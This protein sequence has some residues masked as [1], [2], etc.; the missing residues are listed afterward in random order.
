MHRHSRSFYFK[1]SVLVQLLLLIVGYIVWPSTVLASDYSQRLASVAS[2]SKLTEQDK[3]YQL[4]DLIWQQSLADYPELGTY[5][6]YPAAHNRWTDLTPTAMAERT[7]QTPQ[8]LSALA[9]IDTSQLDPKASLEYQLVVKSLQDTQQQ[10][11]FYGPLAAGWLSPAPWPLSQM[12][13]AHIEVPDVI[14]S[15]PTS[16]LKDYENI[17]ARLEGLP[18]LME[19]VLGL[20][21]ESK[22]AELMPPKIV[23]QR[24]IEQVTGV[25]DQGVDDSSFLTSFERFPDTIK[26]RQQKQLKNAAINAVKDGVLPAYQTL[27]D[28]LEQTYLPAARVAVG[29]SELPNGEAWYAY[30]A[31]SYTT[32]E[33]TPKEIHNIGLQEVK[34][35]RKAM[36]STMKSTGFEGSL[37]EFFTF[38]RTDPQFFFTEPEQLL[39][40]YRDIA[41]QADPQLVK[42]FGTLPR[43]PYGV[44][45][46]PSYAEKSAPTAYYMSGTLEQGRAGVFFANTYDL[47]SRPK[48]EMVA[49][50]LHEAVPGHHLQIALAQEQEAAHD[51]V[52]NLFYTAF[53]EGWGLYS[54]SLGEDMAMYDD[55][56]DKFGQLTY[57]MWR[58]VRLVVD[59]G[60]HALG[61]SRQQAIDYFIENAGKSEHDIT[62][63]VDRYI[64]MP[65]QALAYKIGEL[66]IKALR[67]QASEQL[68]EAFNLRDFHDAILEKGALPLDVLEQRTEQWIQHTKA[69]P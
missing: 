24:V 23:V 53:I 31:R 69:Q 33:L 62:V 45:P 15:M 2:N 9:N 4:F 58:A 21:A 28:Y 13:G 56:Y 8:E 25:L 38:L 20:L 60:M 47:K 44:S 7:Q 46:I 40:R 27:R 39:Q 42:L 57:E 11:E 61:W 35:I 50:T 55:P 29:A 16:N 10:N 12:S 68:G 63:E 41:K 5:Y 65:G 36:Q 64:A 19:Q 49:L 34:R 51:L 66:K 30:A 17:V 54:E 22:D 37:S 14:A 43:L 3:L 26:D 48:W 18:L 52:K 59:T 32:T 67:Q 1:Y 6:G